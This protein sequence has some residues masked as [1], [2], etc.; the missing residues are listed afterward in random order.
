MWCVPGRHVLQ[1]IRLIHTIGREARYVQFLVSLCVCH[2]KA[3]RPNQWLISQLFL[4]GAP[5]LLL[6]LRLAELKRPQKDG[7][8]GGGSQQREILISGDPRSTALDDSPRPLP[9]QSRDHS[10]TDAGPIAVL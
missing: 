7:S 9:A 6:K 8:R 1:F 2:G 4:E 3:V 10:V 5:E